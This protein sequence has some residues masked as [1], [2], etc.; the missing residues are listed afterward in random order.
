MPS[1]R[2]PQRVIH[3]R[4]PPCV[5]APPRPHPAYQQAGKTLGR[6]FVLRPTVIREPQI[7]TATATLQHA[8]NE[9]GRNSL[10]VACGK[11]RDR[12]T[13]VTQDHVSQL[14]SNRAVPS[15][16][17]VTDLHYVAVLEGDPL[18]ENAGRER[19]VFDL[20]H[21]TIGLRPV[22]CD[23]NDR[24]LSTAA[25]SEH[26]IHRSRDRAMTTGIASRKPHGQ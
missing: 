7:L 15:D 23:L 3:V 10:D 9:L 22:A 11:L 2:L 19:R 17:S 12:Q 21:A 16:D 26:L 5:S 20:H 4:T 13:T 14:M 25:N 6:K 24:S 18:T 8:S 1:G